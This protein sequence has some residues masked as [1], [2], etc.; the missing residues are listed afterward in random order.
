MFG[1]D[2]VGGGEKEN[3]GLCIVSSQD[4]LDKYETA[5]HFMASGHVQCQLEEPLVEQSLEIRVANPD[6]RES[7]PAFLTVFDPDCRTCSV[8]SGQP[9]P[10]CQVLE[11]KCSYDKE[12]GGGCAREGEEHKANE[13]LV[14][15]EGG[16]WATKSVCKLRNLC[17]QEICITC[18]DDSLFHS[19]KP[20]RAAEVPS[21]LGR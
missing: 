18:N 16:M 10:L 8:N 2:F 19:S 21:I 4:S 9:Q 11:G 17:R 14:C 6:G 12:S 13:C 5:L 20:S 15:S 1:Q 7:N 3:G